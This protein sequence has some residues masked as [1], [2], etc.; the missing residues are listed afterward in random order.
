[1]EAMTPSMEL[2]NPDIGKR[3]ARQRRPE[4]PNEIGCI[5]PNLA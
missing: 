5:S 3:F 2:G 4:L 1:M